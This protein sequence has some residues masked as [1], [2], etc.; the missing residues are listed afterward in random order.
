M[1]WDADE[2]ENDVP[3]AKRCPATEETWSFNYATE[4]IKQVA[5]PQ[6]L[7]LYRKSKPARRDK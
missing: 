5:N 1:W 3:P 4:E 7:E 2:T 6:P